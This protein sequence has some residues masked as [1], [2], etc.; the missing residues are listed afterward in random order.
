MKRITISFLVL[1]VAL[2][3]H[4]TP[5]KSLRL[6]ELVTS[7]QA[8]ASRVNGTFKFVLDPAS[9]SQ[10]YK[11]TAFSTTLSRYAFDPSDIAG[12]DEVQLDLTEFSI[13]GAG[14]RVILKTADGEIAGSLPTVKTYRGTV[15]NMPGSLATLAVDPEGKVSGFVRVGS[16]TYSITSKR[17]ENY[18]A[19]FIKTADI[20]N[21]ADLSRCDL[22]DGSDYAKTTK[23][24][25][26]KHSGAPLAATQS[27]KIA[28]DVDKACY[29]YY[30]SQSDIT[31][32]LTAVFAAIS[33]VY[34][35]EIDVSL[36]LGTIYIYTVP[37][38]YTAS[39]IDQLLQKFTDH[40]KINKTTED[41]TIAHLISKQGLGTPGG[42][43]GL[44][45]VEG[46]CRKDIGYGVTRIMGFDAV[47]QPVIAHEVG[48]NVGSQHTHNCSQYVPPIDSCVAAEGGCYAGTKQ[49]TGTIMSYCNAKNFTFHPRTRE[50]M[51]DAVAAAPCLGTLAE[52]LVKLDSVNFPTVTVDGSKD[53]LLTGLIKN[54]GT[55]PLRIT[56]IQIDNIE[57]DSEF[58]LKSLPTF[59]L[60]LQPNATQSVTVVFHPQFGEDRYGDLIITHNAAGAMSTIGLH[61][62]GSEPYPIFEDLDFG[63]IETAGNYDTSFV[64]VE[65]FGDGPFT[66]SKTSI[67]GTNASEFSIISGSAPPNIVVGPEATATIGIRFTPQSLG[68]KE[69]ILEITHDASDLI[70]QIELSA[71]VESLL[72]VK[73]GSH[74]ATASLVVSPNPTSDKF[75]IDIT[76][77][78]ASAGCQV[79]LIDQLGRTV[80]EIAKEKLSA[81]SMHK[82]WT[83]EP[84]VA[85]GTYQL[86][87]KI[88][89]SILSERVVI[90]KQ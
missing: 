17:E 30:G 19:Y 53:T 6:F 54:T 77:I 27:I 26:T 57:I 67:S 28:I 64:F 60:I 49:V 76:S 61:G 74:S 31:N 84:N 68:L 25:V 59:P 56:S 83:I 90:L 47:D 65:N 32:Y 39:N 9:L 45:W 89:E 5:T 41:R 85:S 20:E 46:L 52:I 40:W 12:L 23:Q 7:K 69:A 50:V 82:T 55:V 2:I 86:I 18:A 63:F 11:E 87:A 4:A 81:G 51:L 73:P 29:D 14:T 36:T 38:P 42:A 43:S 48:H 78:D 62:V 58:Y 1:C 79:T 70:Q 21:F 13:I 16:S 35:D 71:F 22:L 15:R 88:G 3:A 37:D 44:A 34:E 10:A 75:T 72:S 80:A 66:I 8:V 33:A 24:P